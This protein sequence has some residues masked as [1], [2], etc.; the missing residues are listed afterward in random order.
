MADAAGHTDT[1]GPKPSRL[2]EQDHYRT[3]EQTSGQTVEHGK[4]A[5]EG[6]AHQHN[7]HQIDDHRIPA[8]EQIQRGQYNGVG[9]SQLHARHGKK[10]GNLGLDPGQH[11]SCRHQ[12]APQGHPF[13]A[14]FIL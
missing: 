13:C 12:N 4:Q 11:H 6:K 10:G 14:L 3:A 1:D 5:A 7:P 2:P 9:Q 8:G